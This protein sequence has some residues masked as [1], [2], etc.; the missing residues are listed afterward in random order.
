MWN[1]ILQFLVALG[2]LVALL[3]VIYA[4][5]NGR[6]LRNL[7]GGTVSI[8]ERKYIDRNSSIILV[9]LM[10]DYYYILVTQSGGTILK[11]L[12]DIE[13]SKLSVKEAADKDFKKIFYNRFGRKH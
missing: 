7:P 10:E 6:L 3:W 2:A 5:I 12:D 13:S 8:L 9:R 11:K 4:I 1:V